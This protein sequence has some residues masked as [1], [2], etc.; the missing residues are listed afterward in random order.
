[1]EGRIEEQRSGAKA[2]VVNSLR[3][4]YLLNSLLTLVKLPRSTFYDRLKRNYQPD[5]YQKLKGFITK[6]FHESKETYG[7][8]RIHFCAIKAGFKCSPMTVNKLMS[9][10]DLQ[11][12]VYSRHIRGYSSYKGDVGTVNDNL[13]KQQFEATKPYTVI[14]TDITQVQLTN[15]QRG[16]ISAVIDEASG[17][18]IGV[19]VSNAANKQ[20]LSDTLDLIQT[21]MPSNSHAIIH[22]DQG[23]Q[24]QNRLYQLRIK[25]MG[26]I[27]SMSRKGNCHD[28]APMES[29][30]NL[31]KREC[32]NRQ[33]IRDLER[34]EKL[35]K[36]Y[37]DWYNTKRLSL[38]HRGLTPIEYRKQELAV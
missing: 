1:M 20:Q 7:Y 19:V 2:Q 37:M 5:K 25:A 29:F 33:P 28:N 23:W 10:L 16:Y 14:H 38:K 9:E 35:V 30:F 26:L 17:E 8:R 3:H 6:T 18:A 15:G 4:K 31:M 13:L 27:P 32:L 24:Y 34:L 22:S 12:T 21:K 11:V 36:E